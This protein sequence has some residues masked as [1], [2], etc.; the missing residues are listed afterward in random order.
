[1]GIERDFYEMMPHTITLAAQSG[2]DKYGKPSWG[3]GSSYRC[4]L[5]F[6]QK[7]MRDAEGR[8]VV[9]Q[10]KALLYGYD[11]SADVKYRLTLPD[12]TTPKVITVKQLK[13]QNGDHHTE[14][15]FG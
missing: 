14:I 15:G 9:R 3:S 12:G 6:D 10:G 13:D 2:I 1:M 11:L 5:I 7:M 8:E 4:R